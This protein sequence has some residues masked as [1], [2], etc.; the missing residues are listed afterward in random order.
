METCTTVFGGCQCKVLSKKSED[1]LAH[2]A[3][4]VLNDFDYIVS[5][6][7]KHLVNVKTINKVNAVNIL[8]GLREIKIIAPPMLE[9]GM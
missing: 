4:S 6:N 7:F 2:I 3:C 9:G 5:W 8:L 1:D